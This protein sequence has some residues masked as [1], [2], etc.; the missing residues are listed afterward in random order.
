[1]RLSPLPQVTKTS[2]RLLHTLY[3]LGPAPEPNLTVLWS[4]DL[5]DNF[6][7]FCAKV[8]LDTS[9]IQYESDNLMSPMFGSDYGARLAA[10]KGARA[11]AQTNYRVPHC[12]GPQNLR[13]TC[14]LGPY[15]PAPVPTPATPPPSSRPSLGPR[16]RLL[17]ERDAHWQGHAV[18]RRAHQPPK[19]AAVCTQRRP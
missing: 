7:R 13:G 14:L 9:S 6:K 19:A 8:S 15:L 12:W 16:H 11:A 1:M 2:Y 18:L 17:R 5:P 10:M 3:N 4:D